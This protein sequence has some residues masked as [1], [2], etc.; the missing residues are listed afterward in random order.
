[1]R[2]GVGTSPD[3]ILLVF[4]E[5]PW[6]DGGTEAVG[7]GVIRTTTGASAADDVPSSANATVGVPT[8]VA[9]EVPAGVRVKVAVIRGSEVGTVI[10]KVIVTTSVVGIPK[11][12]V[13]VTDELKVS[14]VSS[15]GVP[16]VWAIAWVGVGEGGGIGVAV[17]IS[18]GALSVVGVSVA[19]D[20]GKVTI[21]DE[22]SAPIKLITISKLSVK[23]KPPRPSKTRMITT[24]MP[25]NIFLSTIPSFRV[26]Y[27][28]SASI[29]P[30]L[31][32]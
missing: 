24:T 3:G 2:L 9:I 17:G 29:Y 30:F 13:R 31:A 19:A 22:T 5:V 14:L 6:S 7:V 11:V 12:S 27:S 10:G 8:K 15:A 20:S 21:S 28:L 23:Y 1:M 26:F 16:S 18:V 25:I 32:A 4:C